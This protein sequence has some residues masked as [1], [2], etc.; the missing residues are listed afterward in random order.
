MQNKIPNEAGGPSLYPVKTAAAGKLFIH[1]DYGGK[2][3]VVVVV[4]VLLSLFFCD[5][6]E[7]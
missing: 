5:S 2:N 3:I 4:V 7:V 1:T 6:A